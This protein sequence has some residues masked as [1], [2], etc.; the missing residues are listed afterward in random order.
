MTTSQYSLNTV[1]VAT[2]LLTRDD[3]R[4]AI[5][6][7]MG[8]RIVEQLE[9]GSADG[10]RVLVIRANCGASVWCAGHDLGDDSDHLADDHNPILA[11]AEA[12]R[13]L[14][15][16]VIA[17]VEGSVHGGGVVLLLSADIVVATPTADVSIASNRL[18]IPITPELHAYWLRVM[19]LHKTKELLFTGAR[20]TAADALTAG[21][22]NHVVEPQRLEEVAHEIAGR[23]IECSA[24]AVANTKHQLNLISSQIGL[25]S[26]QLGMIHERSRI[27][28][29]SEETKQ[30]IES[31]LRAI[32]KK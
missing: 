7:S 1:G 26:D 20:I 4:N 5:D 31:L 24:E 14:P 25:T 15:I 30:R 18:G 32:R 16:P 3:K 28:L 13:R 11:V 2:I 10:A 23:V 9:Q 17:M 27:Q 29:E 19:G 22:Y 12:I 6:A 21:L 8:R